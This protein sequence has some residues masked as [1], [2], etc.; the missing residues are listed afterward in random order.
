MS[1][2]EE[3]GCFHIEDPTFGADL[4]VTRDAID[5][6]SSGYFLCG[7]GGVASEGSRRV[8]GEEAAS[9]RGM[10]M[11]GDGDPKRTTPQ[12]PEN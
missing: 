1:F 9:V 11:V 3:T 10:G 8:S 6:E 12:G 5:A 7:A 2:G 4:W